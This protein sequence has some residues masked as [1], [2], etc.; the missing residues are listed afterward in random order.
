MPA[1]LTACYG[2]LLTRHANLT[3]TRTTRSLRNIRPPDFLILLSLPLYAQFA[4]GA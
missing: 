3:A 2:N 1:R 4:E